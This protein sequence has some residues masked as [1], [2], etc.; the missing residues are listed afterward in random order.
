MEKNGERK[1]LVSIY[2][3]DSKILTFEIEEKT[4]KKPPKMPLYTQSGQKMHKK[5][6]KDTRKTDKTYTLLTKKIQCYTEENRM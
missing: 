6:A 4:E 2:Q 1:P 5:K 3:H